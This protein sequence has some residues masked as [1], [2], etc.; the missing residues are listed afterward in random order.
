[1]GFVKN[2]VEIN[3]DDISIAGGKGASLGE[4]TQAGISVPP[5]FVILSNAFEKFFEAD[6]VIRKFAE[7]KWHFIHKRTRSPLYTSLLWEGAH[8]KTKTDIPFDYSID[9]FIYFDT[10]L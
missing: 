2:F 9:K 10:E 3:K 1:M 5:G 4:M 6:E 7:S 8:F